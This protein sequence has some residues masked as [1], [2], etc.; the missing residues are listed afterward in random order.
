VYVLKC[1]QCLIWCFEKSLEYINKLAYIQIALLGTNFCTSAKKAFYLVLRHAARFASVMVLGSAIDFI[2][3]LC[4]LTA[5]TVVG[6]VIQ[7]SLHADV[8][9]L[10]PVVVYALVG[11][12]VGKLYMNV[13]HLAI[14]ASLQCYIAAEEMGMDDSCV[15]KELKNLVKHKADDKKEHEEE[16]NEKL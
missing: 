14:D 5:T 15:P 6:Y 13:F 11:Y 8:S 1:V 4:I 9:P 7:V 12:V 16:D 3:F 2:G 10:L